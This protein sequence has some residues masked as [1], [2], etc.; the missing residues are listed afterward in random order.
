MQKRRFL[1]V[2]ESKIP[3]EIFVLLLLIHHFCSQAGICSTGP[4]VTVM[5]EAKCAGK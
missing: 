5:G 4:Y 1:G 3:N 2:D